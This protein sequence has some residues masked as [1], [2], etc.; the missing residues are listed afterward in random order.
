L[1]LAGCSAADRVVTGAT[2]STLAPVATAAPATAATAA[3]TSVAAA[4]PPHTYEGLAP[5]LDPL[6]A[7]LGF[8]ITRAA[9]VDLETYE[10]SPTG[11][12][13]AVYAEPLAA[14]DA[15][16]VAA[17]TVPLAAVFLPGGF[18]R[19][20]GLESFDICQE[21]YEAAAGTTAPPDT[22]LDLSRDTALAI[23]WEEVNLAD[24]LQWEGGGLSL[25]ASDPI[26]LTETWSAAAAPRG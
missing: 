10:S 13:L 9:L 21:P 2:T 14:Q 19:W 15:E 8:R 23:D 20:P 25:H 11:T 18:L 3:T 5:L 1:L 7:P 12:H 4:L 26:R 22:V 16:A 6:V 24:L 17:A